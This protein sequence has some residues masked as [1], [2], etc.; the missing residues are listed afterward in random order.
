MTQEQKIDNTVVEG[1]KENV[2]ETEVINNT[3]ADKNSGKG[4]GRG[5]KGRGRGRG[6]GGKGHGG[7]GR[8]KGRGAGGRGRGNDPAYRDAMSKAKYQLLNESTWTSYDLDNAIEERRYVINS[9]TG[10]PYQDVSWTVSTSGESDIIKVDGFEFSR[11][12]FFRN[13]EFR[14]CLEEFY[15]NQ[16]LD[17][18]MKPVYPRHRYSIASTDEKTGKTGDTGTTEPKRGPAQ[19]WVMTFYF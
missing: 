5:G 6:R 15:T 10:Q 17:F 9:R 7:Q 16:N 18:R 4:R 2:V 19:K 8:G 14:E 3:V 13:P 12:R 1:T 11:D